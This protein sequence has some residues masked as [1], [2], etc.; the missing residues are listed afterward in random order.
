[1]PLVPA[2]FYAE[3]NPNL[4]GTASLVYS[5]VFYGSHPAG[6]TTADT[7]TAYAVAVD[8]SGRAYVV[9]S[10]LD[11]TLPMRNGF[12]TTYAGDN[13]SSTFN[14][15]GDGFLA[16]FDPSLSGDASLVYSTYLGGAGADA[17]YAVAAAGIG[18]AVVT[19]STQSSDFPTTSD[20]GSLG[21][22]SSAFLTRINTNSSGA[23]SLVE[24]DLFGGRGP[25]LDR[26]PRSCRRRDWKHIP[27]RLHDIA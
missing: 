13:T 15:V 26:G 14:G 7:T 2:A 8:S 17:A 24:S 12:D 11:A 3:I 27:C 1:M 21:G 20:F 10:T 22:T 19:G 9:G 25:R 4:S 16:V 18:Q 23:A 5:T 6:S